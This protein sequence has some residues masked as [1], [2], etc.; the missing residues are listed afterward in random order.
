MPRILNE[1]TVERAVLGVLLQKD[2]FAADRG[3]QGA[4]VGWVSPGGPAERAGLIGMSESSA[5]EPVLGHVIV[6]IEDTEIRREADLYQALEAFRAGDEVRVRVLRPGPG[7]G[8]PAEL[9]VRL[10]SARR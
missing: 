10:G 4:V 9:R 1:G 2:L 3:L 8:R 7:E 5:G 6:G